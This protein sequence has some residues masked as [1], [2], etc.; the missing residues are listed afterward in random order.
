MVNLKFVFFL[1]FIL[2]TNFILNSCS[3]PKNAVSVNSPQNEANINSN[4][5]FERKMPKLITVKASLS[6]EPPLAMTFE[7]D[8]A[9]RS[10]RKAVDGNFEYYSQIY[11]LG[12][13][14]QPDQTVSESGGEFVEIC[15]TINDNKSWE[16][17]R[18]VAP[19]VY[20]TISSN[21]SELGKISNFKVIMSQG[22]RRIE[23]DLDFS[24]TYGNLKIE[25][26]T[27]KLISGKFAISDNVLSVNGDFTTNFQ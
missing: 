18:P 8:Y 3:Q 23:R 25:N 22:K 2:L 17:K 26:S 20:Y 11:C 14:N 10:A 7:F 15:F 21:R 12:H 9:N 1:L 19:G 16:D 4:N 13:S 5:I 6:D 27:D 24:R